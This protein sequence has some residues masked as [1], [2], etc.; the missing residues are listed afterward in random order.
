VYG[1]APASVVAAP[2]ADEG[3]EG[4]EMAGGGGG[5][6]G[7]LQL[8]GDAGWSAAQGGEGCALLGFAHNRTAVCL[9]ACLFH[10]VLCWEALHTIVGVGLQ[11][12]AHTATYVKLSRVLTTTPYAAHRSSHLTS[13][14]TS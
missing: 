8:Q 3:E 4:G 11:A 9:S 12:H 14:H 1:R 6:P 13:S 10:F 5:K 2:T 7:A